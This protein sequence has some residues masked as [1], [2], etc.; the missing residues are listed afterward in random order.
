MHNHGRIQPK[1]NHAPK[2]LVSTVRFNPRGCDGTERPEVQFYDPTLTG[3][4]K[5]RMLPHNFY[6]DPT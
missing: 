4:R 5:V 6:D 3:T 2:L 1:E